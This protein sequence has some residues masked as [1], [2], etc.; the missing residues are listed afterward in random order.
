MD[1]LYRRRIQTGHVSFDELYVKFFGDIP[2]EQNSRTSQSELFESLYQKYHDNAKDISCQRMFDDLY[3]K[4]VNE[5]RVF[6]GGDDS[7]DFV[8]ALINNSSNASTYKLTIASQEKS[9]ITSYQTTT[10]SISQKGNNNMSNSIQT[11]DDS[12]RLPSITN[13]L[14]N[15]T[16][17][18]CSSEIKQNSK[19]SSFSPK[20]PIKQVPEKIQT[21]SSTRLNSSSSSKIPLII[22]DTGSSRV[23]R[24]R[25]TKSP[26]N[27]ID[28]SPT[29][30]TPT[31]EFGNKLIDALKYSD[32]NCK[33]NNYKE[34]NVVK[35]FSLISNFDDEDNHSKKTIK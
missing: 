28:D 23:L 14:Q 31:N 27:D 25:R 32:N 1:S 24:K 16:S 35:K 3:L 34:T 10:S 20:S 30:I 4:Y 12:L 5:L 17:I 29:L 18:S 26:G 7:N 2:E 11:I 21:R 9:N 6:S 13:P 22:N 15:E 8:Y 19:F 33:K